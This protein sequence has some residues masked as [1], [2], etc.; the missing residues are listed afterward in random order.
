V[1]EGSYDRQGKFP[2]YETSAYRIGLPAREA[3][4]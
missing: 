3:S 2:D 4:L 1:V